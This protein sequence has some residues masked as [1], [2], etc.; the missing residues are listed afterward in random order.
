MAKYDF[1][2]YTVDGDIIEC[3]HNVMIDEIYTFRCVELD[4][5]RYYYDTSKVEQKWF[6]VSY[7]DRTFT[8]LKI[9]GKD[10]LYNK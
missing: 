7:M 3:R 6:D 10:P 2:G 9:N 1:E 4:T 5:E 8:I